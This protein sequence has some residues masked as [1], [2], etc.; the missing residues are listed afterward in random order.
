MTTE[1]L[2]P[3]S[4]AEPARQEHPTVR[5]STLRFEIP[6]TAIK[7]STHL[8]WLDEAEFITSTGDHF[9]KFDVN[10]PSGSRRTA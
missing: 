2:S 3:R 8:I 6:D 9:W 7:S 5:T 1:K 4:L 10:R